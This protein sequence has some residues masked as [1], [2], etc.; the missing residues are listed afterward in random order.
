VSKRIPTPVRLQRSA[1]IFNNFNNLYYLRCRAVAE[2]GS[3]R[4]RYPHVHTAPAADIYRV[5]TR[6]S[7]GRPPPPMW[8]PCVSAAT[9]PGGLE[10]ETQTWLSKRS[11]TKNLY[12]EWFAIT[13]SSIPS[14]VTY[15]PFLGAKY[16]SHASRML[17]KVRV[18][19]HFQARNANL[20][21]LLGA[22]QAYTAAGVL[23]RDISTGN[24]MI[25]QDKKTKERRGVLIDWDMSLLSQ[26][27]EGEARIGRIVSYGPRMLSTSR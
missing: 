13:S 22:Q 5:L 1:L 10:P 14:L 19:V 20:A 18:I 6:Q 2:R 27:H 3:L 4:R 15:R 17:S 24:I 23:H 9:S 21:S 25:V 12:I 11:A 26:K 7:A 8:H 16:C